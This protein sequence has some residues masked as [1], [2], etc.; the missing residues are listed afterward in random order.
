VQQQH[1]EIAFSNAGN[2]YG[3]LASRRLATGLVSALAILVED[4]TPKQV[5]GYFAHCTVRKKLGL[6]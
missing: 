2:E 4:Q 6:I 1:R 5:L 3:V